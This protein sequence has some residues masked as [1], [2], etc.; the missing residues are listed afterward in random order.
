[1]AAQTV[2]VGII[3]TGIGAE[4]I[5]ALGETPGA[6]V[7]AVCSAQR[8]RAEAMARQFDIP[9]ATT[10]YRDLLDRDIDAVVITTPPAL[11]HRMA[12]DAIVAGKHVLCEKPLAATL[13]EA[14]EMRDAAEAAGIVH[15][16]NHQT[17]FGAT[18]LEARRLIE[19]GYL[20]TPTL[21]DAR[22]SMNPVDYLRGP[23]WSTSKADWFVDG[24]QGGGILAGSGGP[25]L[26]DLL[27]WYWGEVEA[28]T[29]TATVTVPTI[30]LA[31]GS[32]RSGITAPDGFIA[33][34]RFASGAM[35]TVRGVPI[36]Y[37][38]GGFSFE[39][40]GTAGALLITHTNLQGATAADPAPQDLPV[41]NA[42]H[43][44]V[45]IV[46]RFISAIQ[47]GEP[48]P[49]P[50]FNDGVAVQAILDALNEAIAT[51]AWVRT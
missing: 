2:R 41:P 12:L 51:G 44:R 50:N 17:R 49:S 37:H 43:D 38:R 34:L 27:R 21:A 14:I 3:G 32:E 29:C 18:Y 8:A 9:R 6:V 10:D 28:V 26:F 20:G 11:H 36:A 7:A 1:M 15:M 22:I 46:M 24:A 19:A 23:M 35:A 42:P 25:H 47:K 4:H 13:A 48:A 16:I 40:N 30:T 39:F 33:L 45:G 31:D 5:K